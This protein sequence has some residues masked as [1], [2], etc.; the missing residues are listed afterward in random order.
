[1]P[2]L[3]L[4]EVIQ[5]SSRFQAQLS[6]VKKTNKTSLHIHL[7]GYETEKSP[8]RHRW[9]CCYIWF[10][11]KGVV[12]WF[13]YIFRSINK[14]T[15][16]LCQQCFTEKYLCILVYNLYIYL[17]IPNCRDLMGAVLQYD[18]CKW[19][20]CI[21]KKK[22]HLQNIHDVFRHSRGQ[23]TSTRHLKSVYMIYMVVSLLSIKSF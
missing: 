3:P 17:N 8:V 11:Y 16:T 12:T 22:C 10:A 19:W 14:V 15:G 5:T 1:M 20:I 7:V 21:Y 13:S 2:P 23:E 6:E 9:M 4:T 18:M